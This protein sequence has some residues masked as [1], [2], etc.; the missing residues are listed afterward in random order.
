MSRLVIKDLNESR[1]LDRQAMRAV[2]GGSYRGTRHLANYSSNLTRLQ[3]PGTALGDLLTFRFD[4][5]TES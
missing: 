2:V 1:E 3:Q 5:P 4:H